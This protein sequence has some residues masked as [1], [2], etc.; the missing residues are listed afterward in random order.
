METV[1]EWRQ[2]EFSKRTFLC[3]V[4]FWE[5]IFRYI[6][7]YIKSVVWEK[8]NITFL[9]WTLKRMSEIMKIE[10]RDDPV[11]TLSGDCSDKPIVYVAKLQCTPNIQ[12]CHC[13]YLN[14][15]AC[16]PKHETDTSLYTTYFTFFHL[17]FFI[18]PWNCDWIEQCKK[19]SIVLAEK[20]SW[21]SKLE[22]N[23]FCK[24]LEEHDRRF[25]LYYIQIQFIIK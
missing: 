16:S 22:T 6:K 2:F 25:W 17:F 15:D 12:Q 13:N 4:W 21:E 8:E 20:K 14:K 23:N 5:G 3:E 18:I 19:G 9:N 7:F 11:S 24:W 1:Q 10:V